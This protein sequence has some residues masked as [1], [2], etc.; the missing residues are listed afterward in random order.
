MFSRLCSAFGNQNSSYNHKFYKCIH[1]SV[2]YV[3]TVEFIYI[4]TIVN[5]RFT[6]VYITCC[7]ECNNCGFPSSLLYLSFYHTLG[8]VPSAIPLCVLCRFAPCVRSFCLSRSLSP[9]ALC[10]RIAGGVCAVAPPPVLRTVG[11]DVSAG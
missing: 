9:L 4:L 7:I 6:R 2:T 3:L 10:S 5:P 11:S 8:L 1:I